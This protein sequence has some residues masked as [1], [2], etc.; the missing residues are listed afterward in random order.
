LNTKHENYSFLLWKASPKLASG[1]GQGE[2]KTNKMKTIFY[3]ILLLFGLCSHAQ[4]EYN[5]VPQKFYLHTQ[6]E[7]LQQHLQQHP[8]SN[9]FF[10]PRYVA[11]DSTFIANRKEHLQQTVI[12]VNQQNLVLWERKKDRE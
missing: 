1:G 5:F 12:D 10:Q 2:E 8:N 7:L 9:P 3:S 4:E 6:G 11:V